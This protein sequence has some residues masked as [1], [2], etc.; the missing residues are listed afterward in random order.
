MTP[1]KFSTPTPRSW[2]TVEQAKH[3]KL[4]K[5]AYEGGIYPWDK[6]ISSPYL[7]RALK[8]QPTYEADGAWPWE[9]AFFPKPQQ[10]PRPRSKDARSSR[11]SGSLH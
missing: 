4:G 5:K 11:G 10:W 6:P 8:G 9:E 3:F 1:D 7:D 2:K